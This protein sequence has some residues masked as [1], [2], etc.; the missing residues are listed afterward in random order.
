MGGYGCSSAAGPTKADVAAFHLGYAVR[1]TII[2]NGPTTN[3][4]DALRGEQF[5]ESSP[6]AARGGAAMPIPFAERAYRVFL[7]HGMLVTGDGAP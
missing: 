6:L 1:R 4:G 7:F 3:F 2:T 5:F